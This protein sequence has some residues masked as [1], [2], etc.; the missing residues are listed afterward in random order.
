L[1]ETETDWAWSA[2]AEQSLLGALLLDNTAFDQ[3]GDLVTDEDFYAGDHRRIFR[4]I[5][6]LIDAAKVADLVTVGEYLERED[7]AKS[8]ATG[9]QGYMG[10]L[11][12][13]TPSALHARR[14]AEIVKDRS[15]CRRLYAVANDIAVG[16]RNRGGR[17]VRQL[18]DDAQARML[19]VGERGFGAEQFRDM[20]S[21]MSEVF[22]FVDQ[23]FRRDKD[24]VVTGVPTGFRDLD[25]QTTG[26]QGGELII[27]A[28]RPG[29]GKSALSLNIA[30]NAA[31][32]TGK[33][34][35]LFNL[36][37]SN[38]QTGLRLLA[39]KAG[40]NVQR[41]VTGRLNDTEWQ[42]LS[43][44][45]GKLH[46]VP[47]LFNEDAGLT[48][49][50]M[51]TLARRAFRAHGGLS[52]ILIDYVQ[53]MLSGDSDS[54][55]ANEL[56]GI[57][58]GLKLLAKELQVPV[59]ALSQLS[60][61]CEERANKRPV[62]SDLRD[63][64][65]IEQDADII[66]FIY[67]DDYYNANTL[68]KGIAEIIVSKQRNGPVGTVRLHFRADMTRFEDESALQEARAA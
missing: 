31:R 58:R 4:A 29:M 37:M 3:V 39:A 52:V 60:R 17:D 13:H 49:G 23:Q 11:A 8:L 27:L 30:E 66:L 41:L 7:P 16:A 64:G 28:A 54:N 12:Q 38:R 26:M 46:D 45:M 14:Y 53:L 50:E 24:D 15:T 19:A 48:I 55:R 56:A 59:L 10:S 44:G 63:S 21:V 57:T 33:P 5:A 35:L 62:M 9:I 51:R 32:S 2:E 6:K 42:R 22:E 67:R 1:S 65:A 68:D 25:V 43:A 61:K 20:R 36:E 40:V 47:L 34:G 18:I